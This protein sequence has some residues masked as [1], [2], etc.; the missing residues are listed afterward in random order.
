MT[1]RLFTLSAA[2]A[3]AAL[4][5]PVLGSG[6]GQVG[7]G[8]LQTLRLGDQIRVADLRLTC[9]VV[10]RSGGTVLE[11]VRDEPRRN[12]YGVRLRRG[13]VTV[14]RFERPALAQTVFRAADGERQFAVCSRP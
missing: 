2:A 12:T 3:A 7:A 8:D 9:G 11:C 4:I 6:S 14:F 13:G 5:A 1:R 10:R